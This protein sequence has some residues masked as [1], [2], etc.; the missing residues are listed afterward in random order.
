MYLCTYNN[1]TCVFFPSNVGRVL[2]F[3]TDGVEVTGQAANRHRAL[4]ISRE[5]NARSGYRRR[6]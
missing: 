3:G 5:R 6:R 1:P 4:V 2:K